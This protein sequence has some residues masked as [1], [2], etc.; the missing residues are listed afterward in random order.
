M[1]VDWESTFSSWA[2]PPGKTEQEGCENAEGAI[3]NAIAAS[4]K[5]KSRNIKVFT[6][7]SY[8]NNT[9]VRQDSDV[10]IGILC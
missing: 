1:S 2:K 4:D 3:K 6:Q 5:L 10:D 8:Q 9:N 7:G